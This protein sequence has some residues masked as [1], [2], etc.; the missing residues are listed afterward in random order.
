M[1]VNRFVVTGWGFA[2]MILAISGF[3]FLGGWRSVKVVC[4]RSVFFR[5]WGRW[6]FGFRFFLGSY[7]VV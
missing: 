4:V 7:K 1:G 6:E 5:R 2:F 3:Y